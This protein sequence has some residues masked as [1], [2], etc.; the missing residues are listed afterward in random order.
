[1]RLEIRSWR[2][3]LVNNTLWAP[4]CLHWCFEK[5][6]GVPDHLVGIISLGAGIWG[7]CDSWAATA[8]K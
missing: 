8:K 5:G 7:I 4:L 6:I 1:M 3:S 2:K